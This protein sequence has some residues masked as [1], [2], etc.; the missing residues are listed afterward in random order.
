MEILKE[1]RESMNLTQNE[2]AKKIGVSLS[3]YI[4]VESRNEK[5][6]QRI[7]I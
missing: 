5:T 2:F 4:K 7:Y 3:F 6:E 1:F